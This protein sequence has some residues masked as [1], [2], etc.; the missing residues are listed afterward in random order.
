MFNVEIVY[1][2]GY[3]K[4]IFEPVIKRPHAGVGRMQ[5]L[6]EELSSEGVSVSDEKSSSADCFLYV[7]TKIP[8][9]ADERPRIYYSMESPSIIDHQENI[10]FLRPK[11]GLITYLENIETQAQKKLVKIAVEPPKPRRPGVFAGNEIPISMI[12]SN[13][14]GLLDIEYQ[15]RRKIID[16]L[17]SLNLGFE[18]YGRGW[19]RAKPRNRFVRSLGRL[20]SDDYL[21]LLT[22]WSV[23]KAYFGEV[24]DKYD[25]LERSRFT[26]ICENSRAAGYTS[27]K[28]FDALSMCAL[29]IY[30]GA[31]IPAELAGISQSIFQVESVQEI[32]CVHSG[33]TTRD[34]FRR[35]KAIFEWMTEENI[36][37]WSFK[38][39][40]KEVT[41]F[42]IEI[43]SR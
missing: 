42:I 5:S 39:F 22:G 37:P 13:Q 7:D 34:V 29:P 25:L 31:E 12:L 18:L 27:E 4:H 41:R 19:N 40:S 26:V 1:P 17:T 3:R 11:D 15:N 28:I 33:M 8:R 14:I 21:N 35:K 6:V 23:P 38:T 9:V 2:R 16:E 43:S 30:F 20:L 24:D 36:K 10:R 32:A